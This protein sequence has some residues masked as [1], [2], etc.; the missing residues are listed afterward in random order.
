MTSTKSC[1]KKGRFNKFQG[2]IKENMGMGSK[3][4]CDP[5]HENVKNS[6]F[7]AI[8]PVLMCDGVLG[9][10]FPFSGLHLKN[11]HLIWYHLVRNFNYNILSL[12]YYCSKTFNFLGFYIK[13]GKHESVGQTGNIIH[14][15][16]ST[17]Q[18]IL[19]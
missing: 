17:F 9:L 3:V 10:S 8:R 11:M 19:H 4:I 12:S 7:S 18:E 14:L 6:I 13:I 2:W 15:F 1:N 16:R 5:Y